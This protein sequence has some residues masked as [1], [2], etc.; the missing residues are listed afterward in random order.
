LAYLARSTDGAPQMPRWS[1]CTSPEGQ[2]TVV[3]L[4]FVRM[5][6]WF[7]EPKHTIVAF[8]GDSARMTVRETPDEI[9]ATARPMT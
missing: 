1:T 2:A 3:N 5:M 9:I 6:T 8:S 4:E 7:E